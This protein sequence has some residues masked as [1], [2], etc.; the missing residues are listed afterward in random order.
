MRLAGLFGNLPGSKSAKI[1][2]FDNKNFD[3]YKEIEGILMWDEEKYQTKINPSP[4]PTQPSEIDLLKEQVQTQ[5]SIIDEL[6]FVVI[7]S[8][9]NPKEAI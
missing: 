8:I 5:Q 7:P 1:S 6:M 9:L 4:V 2:D 3:C